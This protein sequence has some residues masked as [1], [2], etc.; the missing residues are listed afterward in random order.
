LS[1]RGDHISEALQTIDDFDGQL[2]AF[3]QW[4][5]KI[6]KDLNYLEDY[7]LKA[8][9]TNSTKQTIIELYQVNY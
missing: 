2:Q 7:C 1:F 8:E 6:E 3:S 9:D 5:D 4:L